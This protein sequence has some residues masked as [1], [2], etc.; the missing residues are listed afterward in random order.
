[1][2]NGVPPGSSIRLQSEIP[3]WIWVLLDCYIYYRTGDWWSLGYKL[4]EAAVAES[5]EVNHRYEIRIRVVEKPKVEL[6]QRVTPQP[7]RKPSMPVKV[8]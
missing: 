7:G 6:R 3:S 4:G 5:D 8:R 1:M 2:E